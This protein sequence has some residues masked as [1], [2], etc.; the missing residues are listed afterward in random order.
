LLHGSLEDQGNQYPGG[1]AALRNYIRNQF[2]AEVAAIVDDCTDD[3]GLA[4]DSAGTPVE[5]RERWLK[6]KREYVN[7]I[8]H[9]TP[10]AL[11]VTAVDKTHNAESIIDSHAAIGPELWLRFGTKSR[12]DQID[13]YRGLAS[14]IA[15]RNET[16]PPDKRTGLSERLLR[17]VHL[18]ESLA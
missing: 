13:V 9:K 18:M 1:R 14:A 10:Q 17:A 8:A 5:E 16:L 3:E 6:R 2:G 11:R 12:Q 7:S 4:K 15:S